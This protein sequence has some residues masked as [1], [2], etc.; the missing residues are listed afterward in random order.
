MA[1]AELGHHLS[2]AIVLASLFIVLDSLGL[3][4][5]L[6]SLAL[7]TAF[8]AHGPGVTPSLSVRDLRTGQTPPS[9]Y[10]VTISRT[11]YEDAFDETSPLNTDMLEEIIGRLA[12]K[13]PAALVVDLDLAPTAANA[14]VE[15]GRSGLDSLLE[16]I[17]K[18]RGTRL[19]LAT[20]GAAATDA[21][22]L[23]RYAWM[24]KLCSAG[25][26]FAY[27]ELFSSQ[28]V[29]LRFDRTIPSLG[30]IGGDVI[31]RSGD[32]RPAKFGQDH[33]VRPPCALVAAGPDRAVFLA[34]EYSATQVAEPN[35]FSRQLPINSAFW[36]PQA[37]HYYSIKSLADLAQLSNARGGAIFLGG[38]FDPGDLFR[39][40][41]GDMP[42]VFLHAAIFYS[43]LHPVELVSH[44]T[45]VLLDLLLGVLL[46]WLFSATWRQFSAGADDLSRRFCVGAY[47]RSRLW[48]IAN[49]GILALSVLL[50]FVCSVWLLKRGL[51]NAPA[52]MV[53]G[54]F[55]H[56]VVTSRGGASPAHHGSAAHGQT[57]EL[58]EVSRKLNSRQTLRTGLVDLAL[59]SPVVVTAIVILFL[60]R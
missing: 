20:P 45:G 8:A 15:S 31:L 5:W 55:L 27:P 35:E 16:T 26:D 22:R 43:S 10:I 39:T 28:G 49:F 3:M 29:V 9:L 48:L 54:T 36:K 59:V 44:G 56:A 17:A 30:I 33:S 32:A 11:L 4:N 50:I 6:D 58:P 37:A 24:K 13:S 41:F 1:V 21:A 46:G 18:Q 52:A 34:Q 51:W 42:G 40:P 19:V 25:V 60:E 14:H 7:R 53:A 12:A 23:R 57:P 47:I 38:Q 2:V